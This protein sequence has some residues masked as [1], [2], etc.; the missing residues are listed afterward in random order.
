ML[1]RGLRPL[2]TEVACRTIPVVTLLLAFAAV[3]TS[4]EGTTWN[5]FTGAVGLSGW[6]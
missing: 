2:A 6:P 4:S 3:V 1:P 5:S